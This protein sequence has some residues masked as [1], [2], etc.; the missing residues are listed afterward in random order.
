[1]VVARRTQK[2]M[3]TEIRRTRKYSITTGVATISKY[4]E[5][6]GNNISGDNYTFTNSS[7][8]KYVLAISDGKG[9]GEKLLSKQSHNKFN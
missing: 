5:L 2:L 6:Y 9:S 1:M 4:D 3:Y 7:D 8:G